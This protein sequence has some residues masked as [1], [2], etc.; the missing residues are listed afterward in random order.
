VLGDALAL[1]SALFA[2]IWVIFMKVRI[3]DDSRVDLQLFFGL[4]GFCNMLLLWPIG[5][6][7]HLTGAEIF[8]LP[9]TK[10]DLY[11]IITN[12]RHHIFLVERALIPVIRWRLVF[13]PITSAS[14]R[15]LKQL[16]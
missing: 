5:L 11:A 2:A 3:Q 9:R 14:S 8:E 15:C 16:H 6:I 1:F 12:V 7:L 10:Q 13:Q 4:V